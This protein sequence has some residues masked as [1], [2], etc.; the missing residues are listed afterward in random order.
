MSNLLVGLLLLADRGFFLLLE[1]LLL[2][3][4]LF[5]ASLFLDQE[6]TDDA[7]ADGS[8]GQG[9]PVGTGNT[10]LTLLETLILVRTHN[11]NAL[12]GLAS[13]TALHLLRLLGHHL[14]GQS[15]AGGLDEAVFV[16][17]G[18]PRHMTAESLTSH[19]FVNSTQLSLC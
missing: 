10:S 11:R 8:S 6:S 4:D 12:E 5:H 3:Q 19:H 9:S 17:T 1:L 15:A 2:H 13:V 14:V 16:G 7:S 18:V